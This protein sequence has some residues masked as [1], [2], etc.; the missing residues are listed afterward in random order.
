[1]GCR[2]LEFSFIRSGLLLETCRSQIRPHRSTE[3]FGQDRFWPMP[4]APE[5]E[6]DAT[7]LTFKTT[8]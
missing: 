1:M 7:L 3:G 2:P 6:F 8:F 4:G 5:D